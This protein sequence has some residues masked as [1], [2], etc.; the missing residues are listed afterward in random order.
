MYRVNDDSVFETAWA[1]QFADTLKQM[2]PPYGTFN[3]LYDIDKL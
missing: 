1:K 3:L 2:G